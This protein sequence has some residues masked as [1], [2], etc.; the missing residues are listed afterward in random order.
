M[1]TRPP[2][3]KLHRARERRGLVPRAVVG[4]REGANARGYTYRW[5]QASK[6]FLL[7]H[8]LCECD[9]CKRQGRA[10]VAT[11][12]D[13]RIPH[14]GDSTLFWDRSN[15]AAMAKA[16]HDA[17]TASEDGGFGNRGT[18]ERGTRGRVG[19]KSKERHF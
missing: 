10:R 3:L 15:W 8:P 16:C 7:L 17:K 4:R 13:H 9:D 2:V 19:Q 11:V 6:A 14:R 12:V 18:P 1:P 5:Q